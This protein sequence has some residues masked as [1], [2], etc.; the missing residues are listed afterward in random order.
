MSSA[1]ISMVTAAPRLAA[2][3]TSR[4]AFATILFAVSTSASLLGKPSGLARLRRRVLRRRFRALQMVEHGGAKCNA[5]ATLCVLS[6][7]HSW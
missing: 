3:S 7:R 5:K 4:S 6:S 2:Y 1:G